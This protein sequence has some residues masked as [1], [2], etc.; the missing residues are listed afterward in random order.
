MAAIDAG[1]D[2][3]VVSGTNDTT[4]TLNGGGGTDTLKVT[5]TAALT[6]A[7]F[8]A[9]AQSIEVWEGN[10]KELLGTTANN[11]LDLSG[12][13]DV[14]NLKFVDG[15]SGNDTIVGSDAW[16][17]DLRGGAGN[18]T[19]TAGKLGDTLDGGAGDDTLL[20]GAGNDTF[21]GG[22]G[23][24]TITGGGGDD[25]VSYVG[26]TAVVVNLDA[27]TATG[28]SE[29]KYS[30]ICSGDACPSWDRLSS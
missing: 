27:G 7:A 14:T 22:L 26:S 11:T 2:T 23:A 25:T 13:T 10:G 19:I 3:L 29:R 20:G 8:D 21:I 16:I 30:P 4:D 15:G 9:T 12:L 17:G 6:L 5:G 18:D 24:D 1:A 28:G